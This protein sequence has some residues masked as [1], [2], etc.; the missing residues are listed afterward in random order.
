MKKLLFA[1]IPLVFLASCLTPR[2]IEANRIVWD[3]QAEGRPLTPEEAEFVQE[4][5]STWG[6]IND[7]LIMLGI[8]GAGVGGAVGA[9]RY[10]RRKER[11][12]KEQEASA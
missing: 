12:A 5:M 11:I 1:V 2:Q 8:G 7:I 3:A 6:V 9:S 10:R 4:S